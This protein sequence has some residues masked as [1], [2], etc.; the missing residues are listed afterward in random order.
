MSWRGLSNTPEPIVMSPQPSTCSRA[1]MSR[2]TSRPSST[3]RICGTRC[4]RPATSGTTD[5]HDWTRQGH[6]LDARAGATR[7]RLARAV[8]HAIE[9]P[10]RIRARG[11]GGTARRKGLGVGQVLGSHEPTEWPRERMLHRADARGGERWREAQ[12]SWRGHH[13]R[14]ETVVLQV[15]VI[16]RQAAMGQPLR[17][18]TQNRPVGRWGP[19]AGRRV[20]PERGTLR[21]AQGPVRDRAEDM[22]RG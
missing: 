10:G 5:R 2:R 18:L 4:A 8:G 9:T 21:R 15:A 20:P 12:P 22:S 7:P 1:G 13:H 19:R 16:Q 17:G 14:R 6:G 3:H 11:I